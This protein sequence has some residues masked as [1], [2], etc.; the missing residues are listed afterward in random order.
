MPDQP[1]LRIDALSV[2]FH[3]GVPEIAP[4]VVREASIDI[5]PGETVALVGESGSGKSVTAHSI[6]QLLPGNATYRSGRILF[7]GHDLLSNDEAAMRHVRGNQIA[8]VFQEPM[9]AL[10]PL[11][12]VEKQI[13]EGLLLHRD[14]DATQARAE[15]LKLLDKVGIRDAERRLKAYPHELSGGQRQRVMIAMALANRPKL[16]I[17]DEP[18]TALDVSVQAQILDLLEQLQQE[19]G[20]AILLITHDLGVVQR[21]AKRAYVMQLGRIVEQGR[22]SDIM[23]RPQHHYTQRLIASQ[24][25][26]APERSRDAGET[27]LQAR[28]VKVWF[29]IRTGLLKRTTGHI[30]AVDGIEVSVRAGRTLGIV[31]ESGSGKSTLALALLRLLKSDGDL[32]FA[33]E[34]L[35]RKGKGALRDLRSAMQIVFQDPFSSLSPRLSIGEII[36]EGLRVHEARLNPEGRDQRIRQALRDVGLAQELI[37]RFPHELSGGQRQRVAIARALVL[38]PRLLVLD[39][40]TSALDVSVQSD[41]IKLLLAVQDAHDLAYIFISHDLKVVRALCD[42]IIVMRDGQ[43]VEQGP[44]ATVLDQPQSEYTRMLVRSALELRSENAA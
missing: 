20:M 38:N 30:K 10:N 21:M 11:H 25:S 4:A 22:V 32:Q 2:A 34:D 14:M 1:L 31:G 27:V 16:L 29:P 13:T 35:R 39:E 19:L 18:T 8:M 33:G 12:S 40:P 23:E 24:P 28:D 5:A 15:T 37:H 36:G 26:G 7:E 17:A 3:N 42:D 44:T 9:T 41:I 43:V 6:L